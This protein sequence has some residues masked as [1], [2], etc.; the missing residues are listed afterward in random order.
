MRY[1]GSMKIRALRLLFVL[2]VIPLFF[3][4]CSKE[5]RY[6]VPPEVE[7]YVQRFIAEGKARGEDIK[8]KRLIVEYVDNLENDGNPIA[9]QCVKP[10]AWKPTLR[11]DSDFVNMSPELQEQLIFHELG[12]CILERGH[13]DS[14]MENGHFN[15]I[16]NSFFWNYI[17]GQEHK[18]EYYLDE[19]FDKGATEPSWTVPLTSYGAIT[20]AQKTSLFA[21][22]FNNNTNNWNL[23]SNNGHSITISNGEMHMASNSTQGLAALRAFNIGSTTNYEIEAR[24]NIVS[25]QDQT[26]A[27]LL[28]IDGLYN[29]FG[30][31]RDL[32]TTLGDL[33]EPQDVVTAVPAG[34]FG[35]GYN[36]LTIRKIDDTVYYFINELFL[37]YRVV[38][39][40]TISSVGLLVGSGAVIDVDN[41]NVYSIT[42]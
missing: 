30:L 41:F 3:A 24:F 2:F 39:N 22:D 14:Y 38:G 17:P 11:L 5:K 23:T 29:V 6:N 19:L 35:N 42:P 21:E 12:H 26:N 7:V 16:M 4:G 33:T 8:I 10:G 27:I 20:A 31:N 15:S 40:H 25:D 13:K 1:F 37:D 18:R 9:G 28:D 34:T 32:E 36:V